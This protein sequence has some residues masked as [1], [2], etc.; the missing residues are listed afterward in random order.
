MEQTPKYKLGQKVWF[1]T[2]NNK[3]CYGIITLITPVNYTLKYNIKMNLNSVGEVVKANI[4]E[5][6]IVG[7]FNIDFIEVIIRGI[8]DEFARMIDEKI[9]EGLFHEG[10]KIIYKEEKENE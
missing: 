5:T 2:E 3:L 8:N 4:D 10:V 7:N 1:V 9:L 6:D